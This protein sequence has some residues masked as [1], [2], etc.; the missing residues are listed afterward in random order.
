MLV[1][2][3]GFF[4]R[5]NVSN[6][7]FG[8]EHQLIK[9]CKKNNYYAKSIVVFY[10]PGAGDDESDRVL[11]YIIYPAHKGVNVEKRISGKTWYKYMRKYIQIKKKCYNLFDKY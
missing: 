4:Y 1:K 7:R 5:K 11:D 10:H 3:K 8:I 2:E 6:P 9:I